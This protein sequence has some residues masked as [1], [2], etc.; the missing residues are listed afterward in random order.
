M[1]NAIEGAIPIAD[2]EMIPTIVGEIRPDG[3]IYEV[4][5]SGEAIEPDPFLESYDWA[6]DLSGN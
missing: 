5:S 4:W 6:G 3:L 2:G 1:R